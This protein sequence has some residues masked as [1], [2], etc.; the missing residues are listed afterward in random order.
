MRVVE[1]GAAE[2]SLSDSSALRIKSSGLTA[3]IVPGSDPEIERGWLHYRDGRVS[4]KNPDNAMIRKMCAIAQALGASVQGD[5]G[6]SYGADGEM[7]RGW[8]AV[9]AD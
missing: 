8:H 5:K 6:E 2:I 9:R 1:S 3:W 4:V 7:I